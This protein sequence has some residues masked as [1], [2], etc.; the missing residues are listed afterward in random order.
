VK[1]SHDELDLA[2]QTYW[3]T[4][5]V[6]ENWNSWADLFTEDVE[7]IEHQMG[8]LRGRETVRNWIVTLMDQYCEIYTP[9]S[10]HTV[11]A[12]RGR[13]VFAMINRRDHPNGVDFID[14]PGL[15]I[16]D[17]AGDGLWKRQEDY[18]AMPAGQA[19]YTE[20]EKALNALDPTHRARRTRRAWGNGPSWTHGLPQHPKGAA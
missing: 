13:V 11:D 20:Y 12:A 8:D 19:A 10:W 5:C 9:Y 3:S 1:F 16:I 7:Y 14:F 18:W 2:F 17:Y 6:S 4:G 15:S